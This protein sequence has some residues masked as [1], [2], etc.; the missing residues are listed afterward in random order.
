MTGTP[1]LQM[2]D[3]V[4]SFG[5][6]QALAG[7]SVSLHEG[8]I[9][10]LLGDNGAGKSTLIKCLSGAHSLDSGEILFRGAAVQIK[11]PIDARRLGIETVYQDLALFDN[12]P[13]AENFFAGRELCGPRWLSNLGWPRNRQMT[14]A[15]KRMLADL[16][17]NI[18]D[19]RANLALMSGGQRQAIAVARAVAFASTVVILDEP[20]A[21]LGLRESKNVTDLVRRLP[22]KG[23]AVILISHNLEEVMN[24]CD[25]AI[26]LRHGRVVGEAVPTPDNHAFL[27]SLIVGGSAAADGSQA[28]PVPSRPDIH[29][30]PAAD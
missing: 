17:V 6:V 28:R 20:T 27:V 29:Q 21:A 16:R 7:A 10:G 23:A 14:A 2:R 8:E 5:A 9:L 19:F 13:P 25:R 12:L 22:D 4:K 24:I 26:V 1:L 3:G 30:Q 18:G 15:T 11:S